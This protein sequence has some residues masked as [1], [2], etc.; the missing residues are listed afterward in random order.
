MLENG[1]F[2]NPE[3]T[4]TPEKSRKHMYGT[5]YC[6]VAKREQKWIGKGQKH[7]R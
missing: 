4:L 5:R 1:K 7:S 6:M 3:K 2:R